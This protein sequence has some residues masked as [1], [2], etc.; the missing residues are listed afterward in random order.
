MISKEKEKDRSRQ[1]SAS[2]IRYREEISIDSEASDDGNDQM[3]DKKRDDGRRQCCHRERKQQG[4]KTD[5]SVVALVSVGPSLPNKAKWFAPATFLRRDSLGREN[6][7]ISDLLFVRSL[8][9]YLID[10]FC[11]ISLFV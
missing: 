8:I 7:D 1:G 2:S 4:N 10:L 6:T 3:C 5:S 9:T 11:R